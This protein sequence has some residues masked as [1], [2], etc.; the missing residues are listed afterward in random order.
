M[1]RKYL[2]LL[3]LGVLICLSIGYLVF[4]KC[5]IEGKR[6]QAYGTVSAVNAALLTELDEDNTKVIKFFASGDGQWQF[7]TPGQYDS[8]IGELAKT[9]NLDP[10]P[11]LLEALTDLWGNRLLI[12]YRKLPSGSY[13]TIVVSKGPD[14]AYGTKDDVANPGGFNAGK[15]LPALPENRN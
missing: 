4:A 7:L 8:L 14:G 15:R 1:K 3:L 9:H 2:V 12:C 10:S 11:K 13:D 5:L 6:A